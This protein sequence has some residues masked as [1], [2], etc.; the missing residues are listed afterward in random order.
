MQAISFQQR[1]NNSYKGK[2]YDQYWKKDQNGKN[3]R[4][5]Q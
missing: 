5:D 2:K 4:Q 1:T 3:F